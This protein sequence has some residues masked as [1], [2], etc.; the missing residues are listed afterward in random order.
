MHNV[1]VAVL[2]VHKYYTE[3]CTTCMAVQF[4][5][6]YNVT[7][8]ISVNEDQRNKLVIFLT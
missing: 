3:R 2:I 6:L 5:K 7:F 1:T 8:P 4:E